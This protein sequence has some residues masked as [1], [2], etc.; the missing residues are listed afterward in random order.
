MVM[1]DLKRALMKAG[2]I[3]ALTTAIYG[4]FHIGKKVVA[5]NKLQVAAREKAVADS[6]V[7]LEQIS[8]FMDDVESLIVVV[9]NSSPK[10]AEKN[11]QVLT[12]AL[13]KIGNARFLL[14]ELWTVHLQKQP[15]AVDF[16]NGLSD[17][18]K[19]LAKLYMQLDN[20]MQ[21]TKKQLGSQHPVNEGGM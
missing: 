4:S 2:T 12:D 19:M 6:T 11:L 17:R 20:L 13:S 15:D 14:N 16:A 8:S 21:I 18:G 10:D 7:L 1:V 9:E 5:F 3:V